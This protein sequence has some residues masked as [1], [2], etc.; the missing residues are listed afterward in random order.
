MTAHLAQCGEL[1][2]PTLPFWVEG[3]FIGWQNG[4]Q[5]KSSRG[6]QYL[7]WLSMHAKERNKDHPE[8]SSAP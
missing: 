1:V 3:A 7:V 4:V 5:T 6:T 2:P 8:S